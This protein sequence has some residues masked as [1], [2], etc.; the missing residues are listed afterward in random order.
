MHLV[1]FSVIYEMVKPLQVSTP[2][3]GSYTQFST[4]IQPS[5][6]YCSRL[7]GKPQSPCSSNHT[8]HFATGDYQFEVG[9]LPFLWP[10]ATTKMQ[11]IASREQAFLRVASGVYFEHAKTC[12]HNQVP[13][14]NTA[15]WIPLFFF[16]A[17]SLE[18]M[19]SVC[20]WR[21]SNDVSKCGRQWLLASLFQ[22][23]SHLQAGA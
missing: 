5:A 6:L 1:R 2:H 15:G 3:P 7:W 17:R 18:T 23:Q 10:N 21:N 11:K 20:V 9:F 12:N 4:G 13:I 22:M 14:S 8:W 16:S 19:Y